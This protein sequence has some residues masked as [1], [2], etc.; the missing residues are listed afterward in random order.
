VN[1]ALSFD[2]QLHAFA[3]GVSPSLLRR[4]AA[5]RMGA[6]GFYRFTQRIACGDPVKGRQ[7]HQLNTPDVQEGG[8][9]DEE[10][11]R[12]L[13]S[14]RF[15]GGVD[16]PASAGAENMELQPDGASGG[17]PHLAGSLPYLGHQL[18]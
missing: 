13:A 12:S 7:L 18:D 1:D 9:C 10:G 2:R 16:L 17:S 5:L 4:R 6:A 15:E 8:G 11:I 3:D 14:D